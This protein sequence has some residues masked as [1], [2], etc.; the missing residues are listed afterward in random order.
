VLGSY[1]G[2]EGVGSPPYPPGILGE[3]GDGAGTEYGYFYYNTCWSPAAQPVFSVIYFVF[4]TVIAAFVM[5]SLFIGAVCGG[6]SDA[7]ANFKVHL[8]AHA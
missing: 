3:R 1:N 2:G 7:M 5:L 8:A 6:M 4:F